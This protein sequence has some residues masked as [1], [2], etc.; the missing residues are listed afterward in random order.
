MASSKRSQRTPDG[1]S[2]S[3]PTTPGSA[4]DH[5]LQVHEENPDAFLSPTKRQNTSTASPTAHA[6]LQMI[7]DDITDDEKVEI[8]EHKK[9]TMK[10]ILYADSLGLEM[11]AWDGSSL[12][13]MSRLLSEQKEW[14]ADFKVDKNDYPAS[15]EHY[16]ILQVIS[17]IAKLIL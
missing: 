17:R 13:V 6:F 7:L 2:K 14:H 3:A 16:I 5:P 12:Q 1:K 15:G 11:T 8:R 4:A 10:Q 9:P